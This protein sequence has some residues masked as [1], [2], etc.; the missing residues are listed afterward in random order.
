[1][2]LYQSRPVGVGGLGGIRGGF[3]RGGGGFG[4][5]WGGFWTNPPPPPPTGW[6]GLLRG[7]IQHMQRIVTDVIGIYFEQKAKFPA[8]HPYSFLV[9]G[10]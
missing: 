6:K 3:G 9:F 5:F 4:V 8:Y 10:L 7:T 2:L 1:M